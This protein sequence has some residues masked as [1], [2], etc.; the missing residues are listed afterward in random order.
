[1]ALDIRL[2]LLQIFTVQCLFYVGQGLLL[3]IFHVI[4]SCSVTLDRFFTD[5]YLDFASSEGIVEL[6]ILLLS[7]VLGAFVLLIVVEKP[8]LAFDFSG[9]LYLLHLLACFFYHGLPQNITWWAVLAGCC[10]I[11]GALGE[12]LCV[13][14]EALNLSYRLR[15]LA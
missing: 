1:M 15:F 4:F 6:L 13:R 5:K 2:T 9:T 12:Y 10:V 8:K 7:A 11:T 14:A 3:G